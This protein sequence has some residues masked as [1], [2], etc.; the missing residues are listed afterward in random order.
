M[1]KKSRRI[2]SHPKV[3]PQVLAKNR[4]D[5]K[6]EDAYWLS[7]EGKA[8]MQR[9]KKAH[10]ARKKEV[11]RITVRLPITIS[12]LLDQYGHDYDL[13]TATVIRLA[14]S[15]QFKKK[16]PRKLPEEVVARSGN[17]NI[18]ELASKGGK[19]RAKKLQKKK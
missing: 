2:S 1:P 12:N 19:A 17:P 15:N 6:R 10:E 5:A 16:P 7:P 14:L 13:D 18:A 11:K 9:M 4:A 3:T 8:E